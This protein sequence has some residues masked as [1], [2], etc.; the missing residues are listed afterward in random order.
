MN[1][2][3]CRRRRV[4]VRLDVRH[5][6]VP[7]LA[8]VLL[9]LAIVDIVDVRFQ[10]VYLRLRDRQPELHFGLRKGDPKPSPKT[11]ALFVAEVFLHF[12]AGVTGV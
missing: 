4:A 7:H 9:R 5:Y 11:E 12:T 10:F 2:G 1:N 3:F 6:V 8:L